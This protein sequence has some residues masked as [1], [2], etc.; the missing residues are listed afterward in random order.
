MQ[1]LITE[2]MGLTMEELTTSAGHITAVITGITIF[3]A[4]AT[5]EVDIM[6]AVRTWEAAGMVSEADAAGIVK[7][8]VFI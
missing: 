2:G 7:E 4:I 1:G 5:A 6:A 8:R 3:T